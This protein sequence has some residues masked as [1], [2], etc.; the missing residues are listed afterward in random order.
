MLQVGPLADAGSR[1]KTGT[2]CSSADAQDRRRVSMAELG[3]RVPSS[4]AK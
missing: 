3:W 2:S 4:P 1:V